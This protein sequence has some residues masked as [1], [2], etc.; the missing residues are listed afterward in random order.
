MPER[1]DS[2]QRTRD[3]AQF[4]FTDRKA[5]SVALRQSVL[6]LVDRLRGAEEISTDGL[7][8][9]LVF[10]GIGGVGKSRLS[11]RLECWCRH[12]LAD[13]AEWGH[14]PLAEPLRTG[15]WDFNGLLG[16]VNVP[17][18]LI[19]LRAAVTSKHQKWPA[20]DLALAAYLSAT[21]PGQSVAATTSAD[22]TGDLLEVL[23][24]LASDMG[25]SGLVTEFGAATISRLVQLAMKR[26]NQSKQLRRFDSLRDI[27]D[28]CGRIPV[29]DN[30]PD[31]A[32]EIL[33]LLT[34]E[35]EA[36][37]PARRPA[38][39]IFVDHF[40]KLQH[41]DAIKAERVVNHLMGYLPW[42][43]FVVTG[44]NQLDW[45]RDRDGLRISGQ[46]QWPLLVPQAAE[47]PHQHLLDR[48]SLEDARTLLTRR[49]ERGGWA[50]SDDLLARIA[51]KS[52]GW[53][54][55]IDAVC[56]I[57]DNRTMAGDDDLTEDEVLG[58]L[59]DLVKR[60]FE[61]LSP[62]E[63]HVF[64]AA[65]LF[66]FF[67]AAL[68]AAVAGTTV[69][70]VERCIAK[71]IVSPNPH[72]T[73]RY[74]VHEE[75]RRLVR[76]AG[77][78]VKGGW[79][80][81]DW[82]K[83]AES[84]LAEIEKRHRVAEETA[85]AAEREGRPRDDQAVTAAIVVGLT[86]A[87]NEGV[88]DAWLSQAVRRAPTIRGLAS[89]LPS[90]QPGRLETEAH[91]L[92]SYIHAVALP[93]HDGIGALQTLWEEMPRS[94]RTSRSVGLWLAYR[95][96]NERMHDEAIHQFQLLTEEDPD[97]SSMYQRQIAVTL[98]DRRQFRQALDHFEA[99]L[100]PDA[101]GYRSFK[102]ACWR[103]N[104]V[105]GQPH[106][107]FEER[108]ARQ[109]SARFRLELRTGHLRWLVLEGEDCIGEARDLLDRSIEMAAPAYQVS[110]LW[111]LGAQQ[112][113]RPAQ[114]AETV[115]RMNQLVRQY[116][117]SPSPG[118]LLSLRA[119]LTRDESD[120]EAAREA[121]A[122]HT[123]RTS[124]YVLTEILLDELGAPLPPTGQAEEWLIPFEQ[125]RA[126]WLGIAKDLIDRA[127]ALA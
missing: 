119:F 48:L 8:N 41:S 89:F 106:G 50:L 12:D 118:E 10:Y 88:Y 98:R 65:C 91:A 73:Y 21:R 115:Y 30:A 81:D 46:A 110:C 97:R 111:V 33:W 117:S 114:F 80:A 102:D 4:I 67:D 44:R 94:Y 96:R 36:C 7:R 32:A 29:G 45:H 23:G 57:A 82:K 55:Q 63:A 127:M 28:S 25:A 90:P 113:A 39:A 76:R 13:A 120:I 123:F 103:M 3:Q 112:L 99:T 58:D 85:D 72:P 87:L 68:V 124:R 71:T 6:A 22:Q 42:V 125:V 27:L 70:A 100:G 49:R 2:R 53:P 18:L 31:V 59:P 101:V 92:T 78:G 61:D 16:E 1:P 62:E 56:Q 35:V 26:L 52:D 15:R 64:N 105:L 77:S 51:E 121:V 116:H 19:A 14:P 74:R 9:V 38:V 93:S 108:L 17:S 86:V 84:A 54:L 37:E 107:P 79:S 104:G 122:G 126:N 24:G 47:E 34:E 69:G 11:E 109:K 75:I 83:A 5:E 66:P 40:E 20:F 43:L 60:L 95:L